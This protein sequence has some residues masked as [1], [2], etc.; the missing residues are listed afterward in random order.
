MRVSEL[1]AE[2]GVSVDTVRYYQQ[3][4]L[5]PPPRREGRIAFYGH[6][7]LTR[8]QRIKGLQGEGLSLAAIGRLLRGELGEIDEPLVT[9]VARAG[10]AGSLTLDEV[11]ARSGIPIGILKAAE[12]EGLLVPVGGGYQESDVDAAGAALRL[13]EIGLPLPELFELARRH[14]A[15]V[16]QRR[17]GCGLSLRRACSSA[18]PIG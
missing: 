4:G 15:E 1:A 6:E 12:R 8:L 9:A 14:H 7:H 17:R 16:R 13:L 10:R 2:A 18:P 5:L 11:A 3:R